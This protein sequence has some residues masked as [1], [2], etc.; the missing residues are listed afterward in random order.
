M[1]DLKTCNRCHLEKD[2]NAFSINR[3]NIDEKE[4]FCKQCK[5]EK[6]KTKRRKGKIYISVKDGFDL[7]SAEYYV[8]AKCE[9]CDS[10]FY[11]IRPSHKRCARCS[12][13]VRDTQSHLSA[14]RSTN[15]KIKLLKCNV[16]QAVKIVKS[17][18]A[19]NECAY[20]QRPYTEGNPKSPDHIVSI[21]NGGSHDIENINIC[22]LQCNLAKRDMSL[23]NWVKLCY[24]VAH[25]PELIKYAKY[26]DPKR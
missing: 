2:R 11:P 20:C 19:S 7:K 6:A 5:S 21:V 9:I 25:N 18:L 24:G 26:D 12:D 16:K 3:A 4:Y 13:L 23:A 15:S 22:C 14:P 17:L 10:Q 1:S 8:V